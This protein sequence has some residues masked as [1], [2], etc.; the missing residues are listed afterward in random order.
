[1]ILWE[2]SAGKQPYFGANPE[3]IKLCVVEGQREE[4]EEECPEGYIELVVKCWHQDPAQRPQIDQV[5]ME[6]ARIKNNLTVCLCFS[7]IKRASI[8][9]TFNKIEK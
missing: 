4:F 2:I 1:M 3:V 9:I 8:L 7:E 5:L 6:L